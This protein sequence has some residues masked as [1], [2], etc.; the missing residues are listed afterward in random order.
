MIGFI[1]V[2]VMGE[3]ICRHVASKS[4]KPVYAYDVAS[5]PLE[6]LAAHGVKVAASV[7]E[8]A[9]RC[10]TVFLSLPGAVEVKQVCVGRASL[11][12]HMRPSGYIIDLSTTPVG[13]ARDLE[14]RF[15]ARGIHFVDAPVAR[16]RAAAEEGKLSV[17][18]GCKESLF[19]R[20]KPLL[21]TFAADVTRCGPAGA[22]QAMKLINNML[23]FQNVAAL[24]EALAVVRRLG[25][26][27]EKAL[28]VLAK[29][30][31]DSFA[32]R[33][34]AMKAMLPNKFPLKAF[35]V[36]YALKDV[37]YA[38]ELA[39]TARIELTGLKNAKALLEK[40][41]AAGH[42]AEYFPVVAKI[43]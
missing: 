21:D 11:L 13:L 35:S 14:G 18:V 3:P 34:H 9:E 32:L 40:A 22:G 25:L 10:E 36:E 2:G 19:A 39:K 5:E 4:G 41:A 30:S 42:T 38:L 15:A 17:M 8:I 33:H 1:G 28:E 37:S 6:R 23:L 27:P 24:A 26:D 12:I 7:R 20:V 16:T 43:V 29:G 31:A